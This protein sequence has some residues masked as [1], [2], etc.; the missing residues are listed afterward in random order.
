MKRPETLYAVYDSRLQ[1]SEALA[2]IME[3]REAIEPLTQAA[4]A[5]RQA[6]TSLGA[7]TQACRYEQFAR[8][9]DIMSHL[10]HWARAVRSAEVEADRYLRAAK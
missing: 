8:V 9:L 2:A 7:G 3:R 10:L 1:A 5:L 4:A 6:A